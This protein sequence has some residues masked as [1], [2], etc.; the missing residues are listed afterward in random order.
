MAPPG[1]GSLWRA[2]A[3]LNTVK[4]AR[5]ND[6]EVSMSLLGPKVKC[7]T[8]LRSLSLPLPLSQLEMLRDQVTYGWKG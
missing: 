8:H 2:L 5:L 3:P 4:F 1:L 7:E 6:F